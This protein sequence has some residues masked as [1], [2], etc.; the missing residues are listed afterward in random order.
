[1]ISQND[2]ND[3]KKSFQSFFIF[4]GMILLIEYQDESAS[5]WML[6][7]DLRTNNMYSDTKKE[8]R[9]L[10]TPQINIKCRVYYSMMETQL[11]KSGSS[12]Y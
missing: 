11:C 5:R 2:P 3:L 4:I 9:L 8:V 6:K 12:P 1:M 7:N 10:N